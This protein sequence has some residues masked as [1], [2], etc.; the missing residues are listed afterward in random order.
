MVLGGNEQAAHTVRDLLPEQLRQLVVDVLPIPM[1]FNTKEIMER[2]QPRALEY[3]REN[4]MAL[5]DQVINLAKSGGRGALGREAVMQ[6]LEQ[7][8]V[9]LLLAPWP[10]D[11]ALNDLPARVFASGGGIELVHGEAAERLKAEG[12]LGARL[13]YAL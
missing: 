8:R 1:R 3:E 6:A 5:V 7:Q 2:V 9:E 11:D 4:E 12:G 10:L 13:Y